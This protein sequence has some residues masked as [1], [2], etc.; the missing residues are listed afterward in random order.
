M[1]WL[2]NIFTP[3]YERIKSPLYSTFIISWLIVNWKVVFA[4]FTSAK[5]INGCTKFHYLSC[6]LS[7]FHGQQIFNL[8]IFPLLITAAYIYIFPLID[9]LIF[10]HVEN[11]KNKRKENKLNILKKYKVA[12]ERFVDLLN[13]YNI[14]KDKLA[15]LENNLSDRESEIIKNEELL[16]SYQDSSGKQSVYTKYFRMVN[17]SEIF[18]DEW[19]LTRTRKGTRVH[20]TEFF[21]TTNDHYN[22]LDEKLNFITQIHIECTKY[23]FE[24]QSLSFVKFDLNDIK[25]PKILKVQLQKN[26]IQKDYFEGTEYSLLD[27]SIIFDVQ[28][29]SFREYQIRNITT[30]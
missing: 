2:K 26:D 28:Y 23:D 20:E 1:E 22:I 19:V 18:R 9:D 30:P 8:L 24:L 17:L 16:K 15:K 29:M 7:F 12:G 10:E 5:T 25:N 13:N 21:K 3:F 14:Q 11:Q 6:Y 27:R 4:I